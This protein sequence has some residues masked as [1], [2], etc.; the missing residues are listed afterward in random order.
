[1]TKVGISILSSDFMNLENELTSIEKSGVDYI[2]ID[3]M[4]G[5]FVPNLT[6]GPDMV[7]QIKK[8]TSLPLD[9]H[10]MMTNPEDYIEQFA[11]VGASIITVHYE[12]C[13]Q[14][15][16]VLELIRRHGCKPGLAIKPT[17]DAK[18]IKKY[19]DKVSLVLQM[20]VEP[21]FGGQAFIEDTLENIQVLNKIRDE[22]NYKYDIEV[23]GGIN[24][25]TG[26]I[27]VETGVDVL[28]V[29]SFYINASNRIKVVQELKR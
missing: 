11:I 20:T 9:V 2:H 4:D 6:F 8:T 15:E 27:C 28:I 21:G 14:L 25:G 24:A 29:G 12:A 23:D 18:V 5:H 16:E 3:I 7:A 17:T 10:L 1:M 13:N 26:R 22:M 19:L